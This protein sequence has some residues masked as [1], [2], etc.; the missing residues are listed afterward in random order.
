[1]TD[2]RILELAEYYNM[3]EN[4]VEYDR[5]GFEV[6][7]CIFPKDNFFQFTKSLRKEIVEEILTSLKEVPNAEANRAAIN[8]IKSEYYD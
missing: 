7:D 1:M 8:R 2:E 5:L 3:Q 6:I 4:F